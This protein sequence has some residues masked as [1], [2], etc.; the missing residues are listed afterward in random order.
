MKHFS[1]L[2]IASLLLA[3]G[4]QAEQTRALHGL[5]CNT[6]D[7]VRDVLEHYSL[8]MSLHAAVAIINE[9]AYNCVVAD[10]IQYVISQPLIIDTV[11]Q[12]GLTLTIYEAS[13]VGV[14]IGG[15]TR[16]VAPPVRTFFVLNKRL[17]GV[18]TLSST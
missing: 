8:N 15:N 5:F 17:G 7:Q 13:L 9:K 11:A 2:A 16:P 1:A 6:E 12:N 14:L 18:A 10:S 4:A 3:G